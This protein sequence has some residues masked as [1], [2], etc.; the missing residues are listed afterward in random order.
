VESK[1]VAHFLDHR[2]VKGYTADFFPHQEYFHLVELGTNRAVRIELKDLKAL[3]VVKTF[4]GDPVYREKKDVERKGLGNKVKVIFRDGEEL[5][6]YTQ[7]FLRGR[8]GFLMYPLDDNSNNDTIYVNRAATAEI[9]ILEDI[10]RQ[11][12]SQGLEMDDY[13]TIQCPSCG[14]KNKF[15][16][17][18]IAQR[19]RC[20]KC[21]AHLI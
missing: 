9:S 3:F 4:E 20:G 8:D 13:L 14:A 1:V 2:I 15:K 16:A 7:G 17:I 12:R 18:K 6:G 5:V 10:N 11:G 21:G 19:P